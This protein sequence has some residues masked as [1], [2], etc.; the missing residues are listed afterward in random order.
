[1]EI[2]VVEKT[3]AVPFSELYAGDIFRFV[4]RVLD[5]EPGIWMKT[6]HCDD[7]YN[8]NVIVNLD[9]G[10]TDVVKFEEGREILVEKAKS[11]SMTVEF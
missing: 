4:T 7:D 11:T 2:N 3:R 6:Y 5:F 9:T 8:G 1:M 10:V